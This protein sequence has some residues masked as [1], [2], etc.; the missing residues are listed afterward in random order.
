MK[1]K[2]KIKSK[3]KMKNENKMKMK[4]QSRIITQLGQDQFLTYI[5]NQY[6]KTFDKNTKTSDK[7]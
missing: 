6:F 5:S 1:N 4:Y 7:V 2:S 3:G